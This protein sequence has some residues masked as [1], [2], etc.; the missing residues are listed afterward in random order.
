MPSDNAGRFMK[1]LQDA[2]NGHD[3]AGLVALFAAGAELGKAGAHGPATDAAAF[4]ADY[5]SAFETIRSRFTLVVEEGD[6][7]VLEWVSE[8]QLAG[9]GPITYGGVSLVEWEGDTVRRFRT[10]YDTAA[11]VRP[12]TAAGRA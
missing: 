2:E 11:F 5:L 1:A 9:G 7:V 3:P 8:G 6:R 12:A 10:Y 4:W